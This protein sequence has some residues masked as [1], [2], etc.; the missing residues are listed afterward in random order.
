MFKVLFLL[1][2]GLIGFFLGWALGEYGVNTLCEKSVSVY[3]YV[4]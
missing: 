2:M 3:K 1:F 4:K